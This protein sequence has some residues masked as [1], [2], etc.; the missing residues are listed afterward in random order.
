MRSP[1]VEKVGIADIGGRAYFFFG[2]CLR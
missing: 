2:Y 1:G